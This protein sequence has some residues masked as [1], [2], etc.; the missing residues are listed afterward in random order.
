MI[1]DNKFLLCYNVI[2]QDALIV[3]TLNPFVEKEVNMKKAKK[4]LLIVLCCVVVLAIIAGVI[5]GIVFNKPAPIIAKYE[6]ERAKEIA[7]FKEKMPGYIVEADNRAG[8]VQFTFL[9]NS[10]NN[11]TVSKNFVKKYNLK[12]LFPKAEIKISDSGIVILNFKK[13]DYTEFAH[14]ILTKISKSESKIY[15]GYHTVIANTPAV[16][17]KP[18][19][20]LY[21]KNPTE[22]E[23]TVIDKNVIS[24]N[25]ILYGDEAFSANHILLTKEDFDAYIDML[26]ESRKV[27]DTP[28]VLGFF[29]TV[30]DKY[31][32]DFFETNALLVTNEIT[33]SNLGYGLSVANVYL[34]EGKIYAVISTIHSEGPAPQ[35]L[36]EKT[37]YIV[38]NKD[39]INGATELITLD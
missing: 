34:S 13:D 6:K 11:K 36:L 28:T 39:A 37:F 18:D 31:G 35:Q 4:I 8:G 5:L 14:R 25:I 19:I 7:S 12:L 15:Q 17:F 30:K 20:S 29:D 24:P 21:V 3:R 10:Y 22:L 23:Y 38:V 16:K 32:E 9:F 33:R 1:F 27:D 26:V 2:V